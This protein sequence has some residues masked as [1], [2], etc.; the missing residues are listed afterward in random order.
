MALLTSRNTLAFPFGSPPG[1]DPTH[2]ALTGARINSIFSGVALA[3]G[4]F[5][6]LLRARL[7]TKVGTQNSAVHGI[8]GLSARPD[9]NA[10]AT[11]GFTFAGYSTVVPAGTTFAIIATYLGTAGFDQIPIANDFSGSGAYLY[12]DAS[13]H[14][15]HTGFFGG[16]DTD[17]G[18]VLSDGVP[19]FL[20]GSINATTSTFIILNL[21]T[22][23]QR[24]IVIATGGSTAANNGTYAVGMAQNGA[25][26]WQGLIAAAAY[27]PVF[28]KLSTA[29]QWAADPWAFWYP[30]AAYDIDDE[31]DAYATGPV[32]DTFGNNMA[33]LMM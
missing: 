27:I 22:G 9:P 19:Y 5:T 16:N 25:L 1:F 2:P 17:S 33:T 28:T 14:H 13:T 21:A 12:A 18:V 10:T 29:Q 31:D 4:G 23:Q 15:L 30:S 24:S 20:L 6:D 7:G 26:A 8:I 32:A 3:S 11:A